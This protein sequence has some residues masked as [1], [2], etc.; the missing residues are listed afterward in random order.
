[1]KT[2]TKAI[3]LTLRK[4]RLPLKLDL[5]LTPR[6]SRLLLKLPLKLA[7]VVIL[8]KR[9]LR[10]KLATVRTPQKGYAQSCLWGSSKKAAQQI[11]ADLQGMSVHCSRFV[12]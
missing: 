7:T 6:K 1:L 2:K 11:T 9:R 4:R 8:R 10:L 3:V 12:D 5:A